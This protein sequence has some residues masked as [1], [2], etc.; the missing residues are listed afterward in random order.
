M[1]IN[2]LEESKKTL[3]F[4]IEGE[5]HTFCQPLVHYLNQDKDVMAA[6]YVIEHPQIAHPKVTL[7]T[8][9]ADPKA[10]LKKAVKQFK[11]E[12]DAFRKEFSKV[13]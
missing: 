5:G 12:L 13:R 4:E 2:I 10:V 3:I 7:Q 1:K 6:A 9:S 8:N 11:K